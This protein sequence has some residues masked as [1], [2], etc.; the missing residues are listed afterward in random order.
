MTRGAATVN[1]AQRG[2][3][4][5]LHHRLTVAAG[6]SATIELRLRARALG[7]AGPS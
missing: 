3:K 4:A 7:R 1:P 2:T 5:A 6:E